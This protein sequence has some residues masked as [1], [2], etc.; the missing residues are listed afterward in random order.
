MRVLIT[1]MNGT[2]APALARRLEA[3][4]S[5][6]ARWDRA[7]MPNSSEGEVREAL[8]R[9]RPDWVCHV[10]TGPSE[11]AEWIARSCAA[12]GVRLLWTGSVSVFSESAKPPLTPS[13]PPDATDDYGRYKIECERRVRAACPSVVV[14][15]LGWQI[16]LTPGSNTMTDHLTRE[17]VR[18]GGAIGAS[19]RWIPSCAFLDDTAEALATLMQRGESGVYHVEGNSAGLSMFQIARGLAGL[20]GAAWRVTSIDLPNRDNRMRDER[21]SVGQVA[22]R[23]RG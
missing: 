14:A 2:V 4:G 9:S 22:A 15:R 20:L 19:D 1:G 17:A 6:I 16:G 3:G 23:L 21:V 5:E 8:A 12:S 18:G 7:T 13:M 10:A 11:W